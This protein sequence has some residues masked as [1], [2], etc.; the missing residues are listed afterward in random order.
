[1]IKI[2]DKRQDVAFERARRNDLLSSALCWFGV[3]FLTI[4][5]LKSYFSGLPDY[6]IGLM[7]FGLCTALIWLQF[8]LTQNWRVFQSMICLGF[9][10]LYLFLLSSGGQA[11]TGLL[12]CYTYPLIV[13]SLLGTRLGT[14]LVGVVLFLSAIILFVP[15]LDFVTHSYSPD[16]KYRFTGS[17]LFVTAL[18]YLMELS[19]MEA[20]RKSDQANDVLKMMAHRDEL[21]GLYNRRGIKECNEIEVYL[22][23]KPTNEMAL[24]VCDVDFFK[25]I[26]DQYGHDVGDEVLKVVAERLKNSI[27][28]TD[29]IGRWGGEEFIILFPST[30]LEEGYQLIERVR[31]SMAETHF[32][33]AGQ[34]IRLSFSTGISSTRYY[35]NWNDLIKSADKQLYKAKSAGRNCTKTTEHS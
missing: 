17:I 10:V 26:N 2:A 8:K 9:S 28:E 30:S 6:G 34:R 12:W 31:Q 5:G 35:D 27:R 32:D 11:N 7:V 29:L 3:L 24:A 16:I 33:I 13:F 18:G 20:Q 21:T 22:N 15:N 23:S 1:M 25:K 4:F 14:L 19:R